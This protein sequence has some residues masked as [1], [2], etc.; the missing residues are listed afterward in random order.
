[1]EIY[2]DIPNYEGLYQVSNLG[3]VKSLISHNG[4]NERVLKFGIGNAGYYHV[5]LHKNGVRTTKNVHKLVA[6]TFLNHKQ[7]F[8]KLVVDHINNNKTD[9]RLD[10][11]QIVSHRYNSSKDQKNRSSKYVG[12]Y[13]CKN[14]KKWRARITINKKLIHL[15][16]FIDEVEASNKYQ[17]ALIEIN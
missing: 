3:N 10:N 6:I 4:T 1:M 14:V 15:G 9:N 16:C 5:V 17:S 7:N 8:V 13:W 12:V 2:K 11:L